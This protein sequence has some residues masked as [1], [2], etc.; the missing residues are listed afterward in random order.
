[1]NNIISVQNAIF[2]YPG[3]DIHVLNDISFDVSQGEWVAIIGHNGSGKSTL[4]KAIDGLLSLDSG[5]VVVDG[6]ELNENTVWDVRSK[7]GFVFQNPDN[8][9]VGATVADDVA[10]GLENRHVDHATM[11]AK[12]DEALKLVRMDKYADREPAGLS[13]GQK[14]RVALAGVIAMQPK[15]VI[16]DEATSMLDPQGRQEVIELLHELKQRYKFTVLTITHDIDETALADRLFVIDDGSLISSGEPEKILSDS[17]MLL[18]KGLDLPLGEH[19]KHDLKE[20]K[21]EVPEEYMN[22]SQVVNWL[23]QQLSSME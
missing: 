21:I 3:N 11:V 2:S 12:V 8:Q 5:Q 16:L 10:F 7:I 18:E 1:M 19:I 23:C 22:S 20:L 9:F 6:L 14:Q 15:I 4:A 17:K 13:G